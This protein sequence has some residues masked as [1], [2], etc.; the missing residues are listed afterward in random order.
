MEADWKL[1]KQK[2]LDENPSCPSYEVYDLE[3]NPKL[4]KPWFSHL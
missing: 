4:F 1:W 2:A 3:P